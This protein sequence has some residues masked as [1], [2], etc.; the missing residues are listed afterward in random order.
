MKIVII[1][2]G[3]IA[4]DCA[5][6]MMQNGSHS[7]AHVF[8]EVQNNPEPS[9]LLTTIQEFQLNASPIIKIHDDENISILKRIQPDWIFNINCYQYLRAAVLESATK[10]VINFHNGPLP[11]YGGV[12][13]SSWPIINGET[14]H[15]VTWHLVNAG[16]DEGD[17]LSQ[18]YF[19]MGPKW[20]AAK[21]MTFCIQEGIRIFARDWEKWLLDP[22]M[23]QP[24]K[25]TR[26][27]YSMKDAPPNQGYLNWSESAKSLEQWVRGL[28]LF[29]F[30]NSFGYAKIQI[31]QSEYIIISASESPYAGAEPNGTIL[32][33]ASNFL[34]I[35][36]HENAILIQSIANPDLTAKKIEHVIL[37]YQLA[38][39]VVL[40]L[41]DR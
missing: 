11:L 19:E 41:I 24:Q 34:K 3:K 17:I 25:G 5:R 23:S 31:G 30:P 7:I 35:K 32:E 20:T 22:Q 29:P 4:S 37:E 15:G 38:P 16:I 28:S 39:G 8:Y 27:Y 13:I 1:G 9:A 40:P 10:G 33:C 21:L 6:I 2:N 18:T 14:H 36:C 12:N 26:T